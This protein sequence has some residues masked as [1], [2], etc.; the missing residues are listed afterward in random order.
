M[1]GNLGSKTLA[2]DYV[3]GR[4]WI[5]STSGTQAIWLYSTSGTGWH[6]YIESAAQ[7]CY[8]L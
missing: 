4:T 6:D 5:H 3:N 7:F 8:R 1:G 2:L